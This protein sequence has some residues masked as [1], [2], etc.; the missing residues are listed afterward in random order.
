MDINTF[1]G[2]LDIFNSSLREIYKKPECGKL[3][4]Q[5]RDF[6]KRGI[7][8]P[9]CFQTLLGTP[10]TLQRNT[11]SFPQAEV[12]TA[13]W[14]MLALSPLKVQ[15]YISTVWPHQNR[16]SCTWLIVGHFL[17]SKQ[18]WPD[19]R[20]LFDLSPLSL[21]KVKTHPVFSLLQKNGDEWQTQQFASG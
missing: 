16:S 15:L 19:S 10:V 20:Y 13:A 6:H 8:L 21:G 2:L 17:K 5:R 18:D 4:E 11:F 7:M 1:F 14:A 12:Y 9:A 3:R